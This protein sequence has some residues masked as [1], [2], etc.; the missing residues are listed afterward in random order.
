[1]VHK[2]ATPPPARGEAPGPHLD[3]LVE[4]AAL[5][6]PVRVR[7]TYQREERFLRPVLAGRFRHDLLGENIEWHLDH[8]QAVQLTPPHRL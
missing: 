1:M 7:A 3:N 2:R 4:L 8:P 6:M 5:E